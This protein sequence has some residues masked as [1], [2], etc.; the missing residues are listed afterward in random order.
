MYKRQV[1]ADGSVI[2]IKNVPR[3]SVGPDLRHLFIGSEG[4][5]GF[6]T[7]ASVKIFKYM[8][9]NRW[10]KAYGIKGMKNGLALIRDI[11]VAG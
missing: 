7:E 11:M 4:L 5:L 1:L 2:R 3:R 8:P 9:E 6:I 10:M